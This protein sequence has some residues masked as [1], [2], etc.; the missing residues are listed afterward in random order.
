[1]ALIQVYRSQTGERV[2]IPEH[3]LDHPELG[4]GFR[5]T[6]P[7]AAQVEAN[8]TSQPKQSAG[9]KTPAA[10]DDTTKEK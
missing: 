1:M 2:T 6:K 5:K 8:T 4:K 7:P 10:G 9:S 3:W